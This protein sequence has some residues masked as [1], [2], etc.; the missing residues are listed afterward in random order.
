[1]LRFFLNNIQISFC[2]VSN[3]LLVYIAMPIKMCLVAELDLSHIEAI[4]TRHNEQHFSQSPGS[5]CCS[6]FMLYGYMPRSSKICD[7]MRCEVSEVHMMLTS[8]ATRT[9]LYN[10]MHCLDVLW[11]LDGMWLART[12]FVFFTA[13]VTK[14]SYPPRYGSVLRNFFFVS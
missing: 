7:L 8:G 11:N 2:V 9:S 10:G 14:C 4:F 13:T 1:M 5:R 6:S 12:V 3:I